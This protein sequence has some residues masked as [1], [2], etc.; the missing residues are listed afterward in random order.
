MTTLTHDERRMA[1]AVHE[2][3]H[4][5]VGLAVG[6]P[7]D[8]A[9]L[10]ETRT[11]RGARFRGQTLIRGGTVH[12]DAHTELQ[13]RLAGLVGEA[14]YRTSS[15]LGWNAAFQTVWQSRPNAGDVAVVEDCLTDP[16]VTLTAD[17]AFDAVYDLLDQHWNRIQ[18]VATPLWLDGRVTARDLARLI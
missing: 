6:L 5:V 15:G 17:A 10:T 18:A 13:F 11:W 3:S 7:I 1:V 12:G 14:I 8:G 4:A 2:A 9:W 16:D